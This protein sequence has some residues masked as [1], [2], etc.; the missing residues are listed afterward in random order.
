MKPPVWYY[1]DFFHYFVS[2]HLL[3]AIYDDMARTYFYNPEDFFALCMQHTHVNLLNV[4]NLIT[5]YMLPVLLIG[6]FQLTVICY[7]S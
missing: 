6:N 2:D 3:E 4:Q 7:C 1:I 5:D